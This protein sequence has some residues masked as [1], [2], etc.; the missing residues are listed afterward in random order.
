[1]MKYDAEKPMAPDPPLVDSL[2]PQKPFDS[3]PV[4]N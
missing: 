1:M 4:Y 2:N 3:A